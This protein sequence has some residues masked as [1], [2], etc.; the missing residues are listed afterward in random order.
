M[1][2]AFGRSCG[3]ATHPAPPHPA[4]CEATPRDAPV[5]SASGTRPASSAHAS[6]DQ[7]FVTTA[8]SHGT[9]P[10]ELRRVGRRDRGICRGGARGPGRSGGHLRGDGPGVRA[11]PR[12]RARHGASRPWQP[13]GC[14]GDL[15][16]HRQPAR[17]CRLAAA[18]LRVW[19]MADPR[20]LSGTG[21]AAGL[22]A[23]PL[24]G[25]RRGAGR[26]RP[27]RRDGS[28]SRVLRRAAGARHPCRTARQRFERA[29][30]R[31]F[32]RWRRLR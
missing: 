14:S 4:L 22:E 19:T 31:S 23:H 21:V 24:A 20:R 32:E 18:R 17:P 12:T 30:L 26:W 2:A 3:D 8:P 11:A 29:A 1:P 28:P 25:S 5:T 27:A 15:P 16:P 6:M 7:R 10:S 9:P 13:R